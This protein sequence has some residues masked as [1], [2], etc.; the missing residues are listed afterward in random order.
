MEVWVVVLVSFIARTS[1]NVMAVYT[2]PPPKTHTHRK[3]GIYYGVYCK[4]FLSACHDVTCSRLVSLEIVKWVNAELDIH[5]TCII[6]RD[7]FFVFESFTFLIL[8]FYIF[9]WY[10]NLVSSQM[11]KLYC[12][13]S[14]FFQTKHS[15]TL[16]PIKMRRRFLIFTFFFFVL[17]TQC[18]YVKRLL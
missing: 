18:R 11:S 3:K 15:K 4:I 5:H 13:N 17:F 16:V 14:C 2:P 12:V 1:G 8:V 7:L 6:Y 10:F 9:L